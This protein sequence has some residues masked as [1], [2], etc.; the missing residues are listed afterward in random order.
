M[1]NLIILALSLLTFSTFGQRAQGDSWVQYYTAPDKLL[2]ASAG[3]GISSTITTGYATARPNEPLINSVGLGI[4]GGT[5]SGALKEIAFDHYGGLGQPDAGD[6]YATM[7]GSIVGSL[8]TAAVIRWSRK[9][10]DKQ[11]TL[12]VVDFAT[13]N[14]STITK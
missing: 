12:E 5:L 9:R 10:A 7:M 6:F 1:K 11:R 13:G 14:Y 2:H 8:T 3:F 4:M